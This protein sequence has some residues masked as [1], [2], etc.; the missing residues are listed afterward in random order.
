MTTNK[1]SDVLAKEAFMDILATRG[2]TDIRV[3][4]SPSDI[5]AVRGGIE[6]NFEIKFTRK[7]TKYFGAST[8]TEILAALSNPDTYKFV[9]ALSPSEGR[10]SWTFTEYS[11]HEFLEFSTIPPAKVF[12]NI[13]DATCK[14]PRKGR[15]KTKS[16]PATLENIETLKD[17]W[18]NLVRGYDPEKCTKL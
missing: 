7:S 12:F 6:Y 13:P 1:N 18:G 2:Y 8:M 3:I 5:V 16:I 10:D 15:K 14:L 11:V 17:L 9:V 4:K